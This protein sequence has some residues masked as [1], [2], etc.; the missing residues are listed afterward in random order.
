MNWGNSLLV[1]LID[2][3][4]IEEW[5]AGVLYHIGA[6]VWGIFYIIWMWL[7]KLVNIIEKIFKNLAGIGESSSDMVSTIIESEA[8]RDIFQN[9]V[10]LSMALIVFFTIIKI[11][12]DHYKDTKS[13]GNPY[14]TVLRT[15]KGLLMFFFVTTAVSVGLYASGVMFRALDAATGSESSSV[16]GQ[17]FKAMAAEAN[18][19]RI[20]PAQSGLTKAEKNKYYSRLTNTADNSN[21]RYFITVVSGDTSLS[22]QALK[23]AYYK[24]FPALQY[25]VVNEDGSVT[26]VVRWLGTQARSLDIQDVDEV[27]YKQWMSISQVKELL[28]NNETKDGVSI[29]AILFALQFYEY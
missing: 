4:P 9:L 21:G 3:S 7:A 29:L 19:K 11:I 22:S 17:I 26:P 2:T 5:F 12:Q 25:G 28:K 1:E 24:A 13:G 18:R 20:G 14:Q 27:A 8:I 15:F 16:S 23:E 6:F 10:A